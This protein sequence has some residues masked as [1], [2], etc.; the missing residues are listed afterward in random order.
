[1]EK[2]L[3]ENHI[4]KYD[5]EINYFLSQCSKFDWFDKFSIIRCEI[6]YDIICKLQLDQTKLQKI[7]SAN[8]KKN[9]C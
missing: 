1:M 6:D 3:H 4:T 7:I 8:N 2:K 9:T 5:D